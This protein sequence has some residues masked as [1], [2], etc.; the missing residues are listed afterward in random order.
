MTYKPIVFLA[1]LAGY[2]AAFPA[3]AEGS[4]AL[5]TDIYPTTRDGVTFGASGMS[6]R[7]ADSGRWTIAVQPA[8]HE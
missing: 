2:I 6:S 5:T 7:A 3:T 4:Y 8:E 1:D